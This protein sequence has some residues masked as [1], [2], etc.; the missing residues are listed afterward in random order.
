MAKTI[1]TISGIALRPGVSKNNRWYKAEHVAGAVTRA[2][3]RIA[4]GQAPMA[5]LT[6]HGADDNSREI[7]ASLTGMSLEEDGSARFKAGIPDTV[8]GRDIAALL[9]TADGKRPHLK[10]VSIRGYWVGKVRKEA[11]PGGKQVETADGMELDGVDF[12]KS[13]GVTGAEVDQFAWTGTGPKETA[14]RVLITES[15]EDMAVLTEETPQSAPEPPEGVLEAFR[16]IL[17]PAEAHVLENGLCVTCGLDEARNKKPYGDV[18]Y[19]DPGYQKDGVKRYPLD[20]ATHVRAAWSYI[21]KAKNAAKYTSAQLKRIKG[22][23]KAAMSRIGAK[24]SAESGGWIFGEP[25]CVTEAVAEF[26]GDPSKAG[27]WCVTACNGPVSISMSCYSMDPADLKAHLAAAAAAAAGSLASLDPD[28]D[29]DVD[30]PSG[31]S[32]D[33][34]DDGGH[35]TA[36]EED[37]PATEA[38]LPDAGG[39]DPAPAGPTESEGAPM[40]E[41]T[42]TTTEAGAGAPAGLTLEQVQEAISAALE[43]ERQARKARKAAKAAPPAPAA[44]ETAPPA[45]PAASESDDE[46][47]ARLIAKALKEAGL[48][49][50]AP[51]EPVAETEEQKITRIVQGMVAN[52][53]VTPGRKGSDPAEAG[54]PAPGGDGT[55]NEHGL[56]SGWPAKPLH[57]YTPEEIKKYCAPVLDAHIFGGRTDARGRPLQVLNV[58][59]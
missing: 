35:E 24:V 36:P 26:Y 33:T 2:Q 1:A 31:G 25:F 13:P 17:P 8:A 39:E 42:A 4:A 45:A 15:V 37:L 20:S 23:I 38:A 32:G 41:T 7:A 11:G 10:G 18:T 21:N 52:G 47:T 55:L 16:A 57:E 27:S 5:M 14:E 50:A 40:P 12:T 28:M 29:G 59:S 44:T 43:A 53:T 51:A 9:D 58:P 46:R 49:P 3:E 34:D 48:A 6:F 22:R 30:V 19:A 56:P 54:T